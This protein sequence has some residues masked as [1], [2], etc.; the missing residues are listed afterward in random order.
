MRSMLSLTLGRRVLEARE[1][2]EE[3]AVFAFTEVV[4]AL[5]SLLSRLRLVV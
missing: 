5:T 2:E 1:A 4:V 3:E